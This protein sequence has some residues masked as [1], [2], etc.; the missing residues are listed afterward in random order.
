VRNG[1]HDSAFLPFFN[2]RRFPEQGKIRPDL[3]NHEPLRDVGRPQ[4]CWA[5]CGRKLPLVPLLPKHL[6][7]YLEF[8]LLAGAMV[9]SIEQ[10][11]FAFTERW[12]GFYVKKVYG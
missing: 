2:F 6:Q 4:V 11:C 12:S 1:Q 9:L 3:L 7:D 8:R 10:L 5:N